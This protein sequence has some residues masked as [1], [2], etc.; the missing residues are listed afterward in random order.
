MSRRLRSTSDT[1]SSKK[2]SGSLVSA[3]RKK[4]RSPVTRDGRLA[5]ENHREGRLFSNAEGRIAGAG[6]DHDD[7][8]GP[9]A[10]ALYVQEQLTQ[11]ALLVERWDHNA[12]THTLT[13]LSVSPHAYSFP[14]PPN[15]KQGLIAL[16]LRDRRLPSRSS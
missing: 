1:K 14:V 9:P 12:Q 13:S 15:V 5:V 3:S 16:L 2:V 11:V 6:V 8:I 10:L 4:I 7:F